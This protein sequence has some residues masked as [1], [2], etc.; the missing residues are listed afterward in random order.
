MVTVSP[1][2]ADVGEGVTLV[3]AM[4]WGGGASTIS[5]VPSMRELSA[6]SSSPSTVVAFALMV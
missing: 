6:T 2:T 5:T 1:T 3:I 4:S